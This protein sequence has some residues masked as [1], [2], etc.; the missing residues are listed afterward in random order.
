MLKKIFT[1]YSE[2][3]GFT[4]ISHSDYGCLGP[5]I[6]TWMHGAA[7]WHPSVVAHKLRGGY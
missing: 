1:K 2:I 7:S 3:Q 5:Y 6:P 4:H